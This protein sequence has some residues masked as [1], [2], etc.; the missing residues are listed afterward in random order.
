MNSAKRQHN[1]PTKMYL[2]YLLSNFAPIRITLTNTSNEHRSNIS[3]IT[4]NETFSI[5]AAS[6]ITSGI[7]LSNDNL[8]NPTTSTSTLTSSSTSIISVAPAQPNHFQIVEYNPNSTFQ[9][10]LSYQILPSRILFKSASY[11]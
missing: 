9:N 11:I 10:L 1:P 4:E 5:N 6:T 7:S 8:S 2:L 3:P